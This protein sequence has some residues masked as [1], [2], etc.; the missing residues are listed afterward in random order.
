MTNHISQVVVL[1]ARCICSKTR[2]AYAYHKNELV[3]K[4]CLP[5]T[6]K[7]KCRKKKGAPALEYGT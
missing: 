3:Q 6:T 4:K 2:D 5:A 7:K 1:R